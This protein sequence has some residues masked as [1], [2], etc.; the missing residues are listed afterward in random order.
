[1]IFV[2]PILLYPIMGIGI[3]QFAAALEEKPRTGRGRWHR[4]PAQVPPLLDST[5]ERFNPALFDSIAESRRLVVQQEPASSPWGDPRRRE[6]AI[7]GGLASAVI[8]IPPNLPRATR[9]AGRDR[10]SD[11]I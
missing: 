3:I 6:L 1:M 10:D 2:L 5:G 11:Q 9:E 8:L 4:V 7:R